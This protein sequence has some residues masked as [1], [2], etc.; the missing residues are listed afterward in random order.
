MFDYFCLQDVLLIIIVIICFTIVSATIVII[1]NRFTSCPT[2]SEIN[3]NTTIYGIENI[4]KILNKTKNNNIRIY[5]THIN[6]SDAN[7]YCDK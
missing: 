5:G 7:R 6:E 1:S 2:K 4:D 3:K